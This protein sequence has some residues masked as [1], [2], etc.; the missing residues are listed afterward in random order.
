[1]VD[2]NKTTG[3]VVFALGIALLL[4][5]F[6]LAIYTYLN[7]EFI[8]GFSDLVETSEGEL[9]PFVD[10]LI[11][12]IPALFLFAMGSIC[13]KITKYGFKMIRSP[14]KKTVGKVESDKKSRRTVQTRRTPPSRKNNTDQKKG[15][16]AQPRPDNQNQNEPN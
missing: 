9:A 14:E 6:Y 12:L 7:P 3:Y 10:F 8:K 5:T 15:D 13:G 1:M 4:V 11:Y 16:S 2:K